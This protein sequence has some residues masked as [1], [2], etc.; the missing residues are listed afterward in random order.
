MAAEERTLAQI[1]LP[2]PVGQ[3][4]TYSLSAAQRR[5]AAPGARVRVP[6]GRRRM[7]GFF[8]SLD[9]SLTEGVEARPIEALLDRIAPF[10]G[11]LLELA[12]FT[13][14]YYLAPVGEM[15]RVM[16]PAEVE[17]WG[18]RTIRLTDGGAIAAIRDPEPGAIRQ[19][20]LDGA[21]TRLS[22]L[23]E[24]LQYDRLDDWIERGVASGW[25]EVG[26]FAGRGSRFAAAFELAAGEL[27]H[28]LERCGRS[29]AA[30]RAVEYLRT[31]GRPALATELEEGAGASAAVLRRLAAL[32]VVRRFSQPQSLSLDRH[33]LDDPAEKGES[34]FELRPDQV[35]A[36]G[37]LDEALARRRFARFLLQGMTGS[38]KTEVYLRAA[39]TAL[40][41]GRGSLLL[42]PEIALIPALAAAARRRFGAEVAIL[43]SG[44]GVAERV[45]EWERVRRGEARIVVGARSA[46][47]APVVDLGLVV[48]DEEQDLAYK[49]DSAPRYHGRDLALVRACNSDAVAVLVSATPSLESRLAVD[50]GR[51]RVLRLP[52]V[53]DRVCRPKASWWISGRRR[54]PAVRRPAALRGG[55]SPRSMARSPRATR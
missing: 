51:S 40:D 34:P 39:R 30:R 7:T 50:Q 42:V 44:L 18:D 36:T 2:L 55:S 35:E 22:E 1:A 31:L 8:L 28:L 54:E 14:S 37:Q 52:R 15:L 12:R 11:E 49:Q 4:L 13:A 5:R 48:V 24:H 6:V 3:V 16:L 32:G 25:W 43:H 46:L 27:P 41:K 33:L 9:A 38:G 47:F 19:L 53:R 23:D 20:L 26:E 17:T 45:Q 10:P 21:V 29:P